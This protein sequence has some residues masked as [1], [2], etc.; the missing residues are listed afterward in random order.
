MKLNNQ[1]ITCRGTVRKYLTNEQ[2]QAKKVALKEMRNDFGYGNI[3]SYIL[4]LPIKKQLLS[5]PK[6]EVYSLDELTN[7]K[8]IYQS[9]SPEVSRNYNNYWYNDTN[10]SI[11]VCFINKKSH[12]Y[13]S[14]DYFITKTLYFLLQSLDIK[15]KLSED[16]HFFS[17]AI[18]YLDSAELYEKSRKLPSW[19]AERYSIE[20]FN[21]YVKLILHNDR[22]YND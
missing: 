11:N 14:P 4:R 16:N 5:I 2:S 3:Y 22:Y 6:I 19:V 7:K 17:K 13:Y 18:I 15:T 9:N 1:T 8:I 10:Y 12:V 21:E 20:T